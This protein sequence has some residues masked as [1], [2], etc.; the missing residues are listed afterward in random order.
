MYEHFRIISAVINIILGIAIVY[1]IQQQYRKF[2]FPYLQNLLKHVLLLNAGIFLLLTGKYFELN[3]MASWNPERIGFLRDTAITI[4]MLLLSGMIIQLNRIYRNFSDDKRHRIYPWFMIAGLTASLATFPIRYFVT[5][6]RFP[7]WLETMFGMGVSCLFFTEL[8]QPIQMIRYGRKNRE[9]SKLSL[10]L[11]WLMISRVFAM[12]VIF[13]AIG[14]FCDWIIPD[15][16]APYAAFFVLIYWNSIPYI[17]LKRYFTPFVSKLENMVHEDHALEAFF[18]ENSISTREQEIIRLLLEWKSNKQ[19]E[20]TLFISYH[21]VKNHIYNIYQKL[22][23]KNR[24]ELVRLV[25]LF[26]HQADS[27]RSQKD[28]DRID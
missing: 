12:L 16:I 20:E 15:P 2:H 10:G 7:E 6:G 21:T 9:N 4:T 24:N 13:L 25:T 3:L 19:I 14:I 5:Q 22:G 26:Q 28:E 11:G 23:I 18:K 1:V 17:W 8:A 27:N